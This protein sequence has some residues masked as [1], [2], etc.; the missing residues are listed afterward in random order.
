MRVSPACE[1]VAASCRRGRAHHAHRSEL[2]PSADLHFYPILLQSGSNMVVSWD[3]VLGLMLIAFVLPFFFLHVQLEAMRRRARHD[4]VEKEHLR[5]LLH[6]LEGHV[7]KDKSL[8]LEALGVPFLL[9]RPSGRLVMANRAAGELLG[10]DEHRNINLLRLLDA[11]PLRNIIEQA[12]RAES[13]LTATVQVRQPEGE[14]TYRATATPL[15]N[16]GGH[17]GIVFHDITEEHRTQVI[18]RDFVANASHELRTPLTIIRG[19]VETLRE[20]PMYAEDPALRQRAL[21][22]MDKHAARIVRLVEDMLALSRLE[23]GDRTPLKM[24][25]FDLAQVVDDVR[26]R[27]DGM[28]EKQAATLELEIDE[29]PF[30]LRGDRFYWSQIF[31]N[32]MENA[33]KNN[34]NPGLILRIAARR[35]ASGCRIEVVDNGIGIAAEALPYI[36]NRFYRADATGKVK[37]TGLGLSIVKHAV[38]LHGGTI[39]AESVPGQRTAFSMTIPTMEPEP[40]S[41]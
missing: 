2:T 11:S 29:T 18:R 8:F 5:H 39:A 17:I 40:R 33:L 27:L 36:F 26:L 10:I 28:I 34:P 37:G 16:E 4:H 1:L 12:T 9:L 15:R 30:P 41:T 19:Y 38:E 25:E 31:F 21:A 3:I 35:T 20:D 24:E 22:I 14:R 13:L 6:E 23:S 32:L 7:Q